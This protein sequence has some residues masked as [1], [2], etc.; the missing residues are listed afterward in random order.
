[1]EARYN[2]ENQRM[3]VTQG[4]KTETTEGKISNV[5][6]SDSSSMNKRVD[7]S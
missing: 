6:K 4:R 1:M 5:H 7:F 2:S 3:F